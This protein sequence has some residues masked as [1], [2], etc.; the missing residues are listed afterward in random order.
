VAP[1]GDFSAT[2]VT[3][4]TVSRAEMYLG[5]GSPTGP[6]PMT[7]P[8]SN[9]GGGTWSGSITAPTAAGI[10]HYTVGLYG[11][12]GRRTLLDNDAWNV[13]VAAAVLPTPTPTPAP[14][15]TTFPSD[16]PLAPPFSYG[17]AVPAVFSADGRSLHGVEVVSNSRPD[18]A[19][20]TVAQFY[21]DRL[22]RAGWNVDQLTVPPAGATS[23]TIVATSG[24]SRVCV[25]EY[26]GST[27]QIFY[28]T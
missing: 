1:G 8:L 26:S 27:V 11:A 21:E 5:T 19:A 13:R 3:S 22:P 28:G 16:I 20:S 12:S 18:V 7:I 25:V 6:A 2:V 14:V 17:N 24:A 9:S 15:T 23:F 10:Y 4:G